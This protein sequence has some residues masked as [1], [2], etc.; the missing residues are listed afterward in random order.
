MAYEDL[1]KDTSTSVDNGNFF[2]VTITDLDINTSYP[3]QFRWKYQDGSYGAWSS[4]KTITTPGESFPNV[5]STLTVTGG[6]G[7]LTITWDGKDGSANTLS[8]FDRVDIYIDGSPFDATKP[9]ESFFAAG[10]KTIVAPA[11]TYI[12]SAYAVSKAGTKSAVNTSVTRTVTAVGEVI[13]TP[14]LPSGITVATAPFA[15]SVSWP[16]TYSSS[17]FTGFKSIDIYAVSSDLGSTTTSGISSTNL[18]GSLTVQDTAN[19]IN[20]G[21]DNLKQALGLANTTAVYTSTIFYYFN[22]SNK[23]GTKYGS[24]TY[25]RINSSSVVPTQANFV[26]LA[27]GVISI[28]N[29][30]AGNGSFSS[31]LRTGTA[32]GARIELSAVS[33]FINGGNTVQKGLVA[34]TSGNTELFNLDLDAST[35]TINGS[36]TFTGNLSIGS[37]NTIFKAE[38]ATGI[39]LGDATY[40]SAP[41]RVSTNGVIRANSGTIGG[42]TLASNYLQGTNFQIHSG[43][44]TIYVGSTS[45]QH[46]RMSSTELAHYNGGTAT[47]KFTLT[48]SNGNLT[49]GGTITASSASLSGYL[50]AGNARFGTDVSGTD[51]GI[52]INANNYWYDTGSLKIGGSTKYL[53]WDGTDLNVVGSITATTGSIG[54]FNITTTYLTS[55]TSGSG[56]TDFYLNSSNGNARFNTLSA[57]GTL[58]AGAGLILTTGVSTVSAGGNDFNNVGNLNS[59]LGTISTTTGSITAGGE[60]YAAGHQTFSNAANGIVFGLDGKIG[61]STASSE[62]YKENITDLWSVPE[63]DPK[64]LLD[65]PV[66]AFSYKLDYLKN[67]DRSGVLIPGLIAEEVDAIYPL[68]TDYVDGQ[69]ENI[70]DRAILISLLALVQDLSKRLDAL[71]G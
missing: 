33:D 11:G 3:I 20:I 18:V 17:S 29:L 49:I 13:Q 26:D 67:D 62:R 47:G 22:A 30:V 2:N 10:T 70:N 25:T 42:W 7:I 37:S 60:L 44:S 69:V 64:K 34:Y 14:T 35:L 51:D 21:L 63:L 65:I 48:S 16:G 66:R 38:P 6:S 40:A 68:A 45:G 58:T 36:G 24:P 61:R 31:W 71:E 19:K 23:N 55:G 28:E 46:I 57:A 4:S 8:N 15:V 9:A 54:G 50:S 56:T 32:G 39:W 27:S 5:P 59:P 43:D 12:V 52:Y 1:L 53:T 41:F